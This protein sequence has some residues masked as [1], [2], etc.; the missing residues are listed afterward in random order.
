MFTRPQ[1]SPVI[2]L[3][4][5]FLGTVLLTVFSQENCGVSRIF[6][7]YDQIWGH[8]PGSYT[9]EIRQQDSLVLC[10]TSTSQLGYDRTAGSVFSLGC[11]HQFATS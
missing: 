8:L 10:T 4:S 2:I 7:I 5:V 11:K 6:S 9:G 1:K 3:C